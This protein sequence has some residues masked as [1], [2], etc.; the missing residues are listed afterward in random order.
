MHAPGDLHRRHPTPFF[1]NHTPRHLEIIGTR[2]PSQSAPEMYGPSGMAIDAGPFHPHA[3]MGQASSAEQRRHQEQHQQQ[4]HRQCQDHQ[5]LAAVGAHASNKSCGG[6]I[7]RQQSIRIEE[8]PVHPVTPSPDSWSMHCA[9]TNQA[10]YSSSTPPLKASNMMTQTSI[11]QLPKGNASHDLAFF[12]RT[13]GPTAAH[14]KPSKLEDQKRSAPRNALR[15]FKVG[16]KRSVAQVEDAQIAHQR[17]EARN[18]SND[19]TDNPRLNEV[20]YDEG[21]LLADEPPLPKVVQQ[22]VSSTGRLLVRSC[23]DLY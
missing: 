14:R 23:V 17:R 19:T 8:S 4:Q 22:K 3:S 12:L 18:A 6:N 11:L 21:G 13:T 9:C 1:A 5:D 20:L 15:F 7:L 2:S 10:P 16:H